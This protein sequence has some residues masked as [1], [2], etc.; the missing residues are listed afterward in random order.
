MDYKNFGLTLKVK[1]YYVINMT[2][3]PKV[4]MYL[5]NNIVNKQH[6]WFTDSIYGYSCQP[7]SIFII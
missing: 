3:N 1:K 2:H 4:F 7:I 5:F 6:A